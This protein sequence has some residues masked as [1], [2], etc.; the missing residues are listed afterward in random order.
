MQRGISVS[1]LEAEAKGLRSY[2]WLYSYK[3]SST[4]INGRPVN[5]LH[6]FYIPALRLSVKYD[7][8][9]GYFRST[10]LAA[11][12]QGFSAF[13][14]RGGKMRLVV[15]AD[16][17]P[18]DVAAILAGDKARLEARLNEELARPETWPEGVRNGVTLLA[19]MVAK[20]YLEI[21]VAFRLHM[22]THE[23]VP[24]DSVDDGYVHEKWFIF[25]DEYGN[26]LY[27]SGTL[28]ES[29]T[30][31]VLNAENIDVHCDWW[32][33]TDRRRVEDAVAAFEAL[34]QGKVAHMP[35]MSIPEAVQRRLIALAEGI[36]YPVE[37]DGTT[38]VT[39]EVRPPSA[40][41][42]L[43]FALLKDAPFLPSG[44]YVGLETAP[45]DPWPHQRV[46]ARRLVESWPYSHLL[47]DEVGLGKTIEAGLAMRSLYLSGIAKRILIAAPASLTRQWQREMATKMLLPFGRV[48]TGPQSGHEYIWPTEAR[49]PLNRLF[50]PN[51]TIVSTGLLARKE[52]AL[53]LRDAEPFDIA[54]VDEAHYA[55]RQN[56]T[57][58]AE[59]HPE[60]GRLYLAIKEHLRERARSLW[61]ATATPMQ[62][63]PVEVADLLALTNRVGAF[64]FD[65]SLMEQYY[66]L[67]AK[68][69]HGEDL[70]TVEWEF[71]RR[72]VSALGREDPLYW[73]YVE[74][75][76]IDGRIRATVSLWLQYG[77]PP[78]GRDRQLILRLLFAASP[79]AR[80]MQRH[81]RQLLELYRERGK[82]TANLA[83]RY[84]Y[85]LPRIKFRE[86]EKRIY[87]A[88]ESY[89][90]EL[91][92]QLRQDNDTKTGNLVSFFLSFLRL[93]FASSFYAIQQTLQRRLQRVEETL[94]HQLSPNG[95]HES[96]EALEDS[97]YD[98][99]G[100]DDELATGALL[101]NRRRA[102]LEW[103]RERLQELLRMLE[104]L[105]GP[106]SKMEEL[107]RQLD[108]R[109]DPTTRR[110]RQ[111]V[112]FTR[113]YDTLV[114]IVH[115]LQRVDPEMRIGTYAGKGCSYYDPELRRL[116]SVDREE[117]KRRYLRGEVDVLICTDAAAEGLNLQSA[118]L[119]INFDLGWNP[120]KIEQRIGRIDRIGQRHSNIYVLNLC[121]V[122]SAEEI[123][124]GRLLE[125]LEKANLIVGRQQVSLLPVMPEEF[126]ALAEGTITLDELERR[127]IQ[128][129]QEQQRRIES[130]EMSAAD[131]YEIYMRMEEE[132]TG[133]KAPIT[134]DAIWE[135][136]TQSQYLRDLG[137]E[138]L[139]DSA[140]PALRVRGLD[141]VPD[142]TLLTVSRKLYEE[143]PDARTPVHFA[144][145]GDPVFDRIL[146]HL[147]SFDLPA[148][149][150]RL[151]VQVPGLTD[152]EMVAYVVAAK[153]GN[154]LVT[155]RLVKRWEDLRGLELATD[156]VLSPDE[157]ETFRRELL[158]LA[159][160]E[161]QTYHAAR[162]VERDNLRAAYAH[163]AFEL[164][165]IN[166]LLRERSRSAGDDAL[167]G[168][169]IEEVRSLY[170]DRE[171]IRAIQLPAAVLRELAPYLLFDVQLPQ[172]GQ[173][174][175][176]PVPRVLAYA[177]I[178]AARR[179]VDGAKIRKNEQY[180]D[181]MMARIQRTAEE[182]V[183]KALHL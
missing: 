17:E 131:L 51:L 60:Y 179:V 105:T 149:V 67:I 19:W 5:M 114:D 32:E 10:S 154:G 161:Y 71:L 11:A 25:Y 166:A 181:R 104:G 72:V 152:V 124:Y 30:A 155:L 76:V 68:L 49:V 26:R 13:V 134:L 102:D 123:V 31:L 42:R 175:S 117:V 88:L 156:V 62:L 111:T 81:T 46:V 23:P 38:A 96:E 112:V 129:L 35:V 8:V 69:L 66:G 172:L 160:A 138:L 94:H 80:V 171:V 90:K 120:M 14:N 21:K 174:A 101:K 139:G 151:S 82:L 125:R 119:L 153:A 55:R 142:G 168:A 147:N 27:G 75:Y 41:E 4:L 85:P 148:C 98:G 99:D 79:L 45:I 169:V 53:A 7:R 130:M 57:R 137:C 52:R 132:G 133:S 73:D 116:V 83:R 74:R 78:R 34:W 110:I 145:F 150:H 108:R 15:G 173:D 146:G 61:L 128:R 44:R 6:D 18:A 28:N 47:C 43:R 136:L 50:D 36:A 165:V 86:D 87:D 106:S 16:L 33:G 140:T 164:L 2:P 158:A 176:A 65:P 100:E 143:G 118:D 122:G 92:R 39:R 93:R 22:V 141:G 167:F 64:Q 127:A 97:V 177:A 1:T 24:F 70:S 144:S 40:L 182:K 89:C 58:G 159:E 59:V 163:V 9:A 20:G 126:E 183:A 162:R 12:S 109:R 170:K 121:Y 95:V 107:L 54:L 56:P 113:F 115:W 91:S 103:E 180:V 29:K 84:V 48:Y 3:T 63:H 178:D 157:I 135:C 37:I 77:H